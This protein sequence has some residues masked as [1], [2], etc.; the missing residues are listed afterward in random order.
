[1]VWTCR[2]IVTNFVYK[3][4]AFFPRKM[5]NQNLFATMLPIQ[6]LSKNFRKISYFC[7]LHWPIVYTASINLDAHQQEGPHQTFDTSMF[8]PH[9]IG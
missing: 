3:H 2:Y 1:M 8:T 4:I 9:F 6:L 5:G 7:R